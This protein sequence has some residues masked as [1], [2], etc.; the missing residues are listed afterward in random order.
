M[1][2]PTR[3]LGFTKS[4]PGRTSAVKSPAVSPPKVLAGFTRKPEGSKYKAQPIVRESHVH[5]Q[6]CLDQ[7]AV[8]RRRVAF[9][10][11][12]KETKAKE[13]HKRNVTN[14]LERRKRQ[15]ERAAKADAVTGRSLTR[16]HP[17]YAEAGG[18]G[19]KC[20]FTYGMQDFTL[21]LKWRNM[22]RDNHLVS[23]NMQARLSVWVGLFSIPGSISVSLLA[24]SLFSLALRSL[25]LALC[26]LSLSLSAVGSKKNPFPGRVFYLLCSL[27]KSRVSEIS[28]RDASVASRREI[29][30]KRLLN[31][32]HS[33]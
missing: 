16:M 9:F 1:S 8:I 13:E 22:S 25:F 15:Q 19:G 27:I 33:K 11:L 30:Y 17:L 26:S 21:A 3:K 23:I 29:S 4:H 18:V 10:E 6:T 31:R 7:A 20:N 28:R 2:R 24:P 5:G 14:L 32:E 12:R